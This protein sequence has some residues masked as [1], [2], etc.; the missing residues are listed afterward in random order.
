MNEDEKICPRCAETIKQAA[1]VC[2]FCGHEFGESKPETVAATGPASAAPP[3]TWLPGK[4]K[5][6]PAKSS[7]NVSLAAKGLGGCLV[8]VVLIL[9]LGQCVGSSTDESSRA[10]SVD[11][12]AVADLM[13]NDVGSSPDATGGNAAAAETATPASSWSYSSRQDEVRGKTIHYA[14]VTSK[15]QV[16]FDFPYAGGSRLQITVRKHPKWGED[17]VFQISD[18]QFV[19]GIYDCTGAINFGKGAETLTLVPPEDHDSKTLFA[20]YG[21]TIIRKLKDSDQVVV[22]LPFYQEGNRQFTF[23][24]AGLTW[25]PK[26]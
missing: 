22:E 3:S 10:E 17:V 7:E 26:S 6:E 14:E 12:L 16:D 2:R 8:L 20:K 19:C 15:N 18:G 21:P 24:T 13:V 11:N 5:D 25:P 23:E 1:V 4:P 9:M